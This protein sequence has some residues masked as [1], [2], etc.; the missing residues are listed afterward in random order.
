M[1]I[2]LLASNG[3]GSLRLEKSPNLGIFVGECWKA[4]HTS[5]TDPTL[6]KEGSLEHRQMHRPT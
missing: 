4:T 5:A 3:A 6:A 2:A 1:T